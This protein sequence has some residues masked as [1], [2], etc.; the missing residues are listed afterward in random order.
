MRLRDSRAKAQVT[1]AST[2]SFKRQHGNALVDDG[3]FVDQSLEFGDEVSRDQNGTIAG[4]AFLVCADHR[5]NEFATHDGVEA[6]SGCV[7]HEQ[8][9]LGAMGGEHRE[10]R[11]LSM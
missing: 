8:V 3:E 5:L 6:R 9:R 2:V 1:L 7:Q 10:M 11:S 4:I